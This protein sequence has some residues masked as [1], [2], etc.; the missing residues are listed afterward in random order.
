MVTSE[1]DEDAVSA[2]GLRLGAGLRVCGV[3]S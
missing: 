1:Q 3:V 2:P